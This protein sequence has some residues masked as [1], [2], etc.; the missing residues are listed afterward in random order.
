SKSVI[1]PA[2]NPFATIIFDDYF[3]GGCSSSERKWRTFLP[4][5]KYNVTLPFVYNFPDA[6]PFPLY[7]IRNE[8]FIKELVFHNNPKSLLLI[9]NID[10]GELIDPA[11]YDE[12]LDEH[13][14]IEP[15]IFIV[16]YENYKKSYIN[17]IT[18]EK[19][20]ARVSYPYRWIE[21]VPFKNK[22]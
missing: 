2:I 17:S 9:K 4:A 6:L 13:E 3:A 18:S 15:P 1:G 8:T 7:N 21:N 20:G 16:R 22:G 19:D 5:R 10:S 11:K 12:Y 14:N